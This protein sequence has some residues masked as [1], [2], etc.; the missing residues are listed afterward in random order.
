MPFAERMASQSRDLEFVASSALKEN[1][2]SRAVTRPLSGRA[3][4]QSCSY[5]SLICH[6]EPARSGGEEPA[7]KL[8]FRTGGAAAVSN[9]LFICHSEPAR[10]GGEEPAFATNWIVTVEERRF[11][12]NATSL[13]MRHPERPRFHQRAEGS[14]AQHSCPEA[15]NPP[16]PDYQHLCPSVS[17]VVKFL[18]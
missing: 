4:L 14:R 18:A 2:F 8:S 17:S 3:R 12:A 1:D 16:L 10:S 7:F 9:P 15:A 11:S 13:L 5:R 6:S